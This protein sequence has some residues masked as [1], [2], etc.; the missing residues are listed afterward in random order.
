MIFHLH[1]FLSLITSVF[2]LEEQFRN[3]F[4]LLSN[5]KCLGFLKQCYEYENEYNLRLLFL[6]HCLR[7]GYDLSLKG[8]LG[9]AQDCI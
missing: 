9:T 6:V 5:N 3:P 8:F 4:A 7:L 2:H 1:L